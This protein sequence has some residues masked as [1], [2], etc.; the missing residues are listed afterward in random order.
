MPNISVYLCLTKIPHYYILQ[1]YRDCLRL[2]NHIAPGNSGKST[3]LRNIVKQE[4][5]KNRH[6]Q[7]E[8]QI[9]ALQSHAVRALS[10][11]LLFQNAGSDPKVKQAFKTFHD[12]HVKDA[13]R[14]E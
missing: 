6:V 4:F 10:N 11:Y 14:D 2:V 13:G 5:S 8:Q 1:L 9:Q 12:K 7:E 3:A